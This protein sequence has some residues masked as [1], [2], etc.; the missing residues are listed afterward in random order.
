MSNVNV[1]TYFVRITNSDG[2][3]CGNSFETD[4]I[5]NSSKFN[6][7]VERIINEENADDYTASVIDENGNPVKCFD[8]E[9]TVENTKEYYVSF[10][11]GTSFE[12]DL[13]PN[14]KEFQAL[15]YD[16]QS[17]CDVRRMSAVVNDADNN[18]VYSD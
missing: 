16:L 5:P 8:C 14:S 18:E 12:T 9:P 2:S 10:T 6:D 7:M 17:E 15:L 13:D 4:A 1:Q 3:T 11:T